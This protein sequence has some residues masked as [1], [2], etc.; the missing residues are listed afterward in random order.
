MNLISSVRLMA[1]N[2]LLES[3]GA[4]GKTVAAAVR[5]KKVGVDAVS[6]HSTNT[7]LIGAP[8]ITFKMDGQMS[9]F[10]VVQATEHVLSVDL[11]LTEMQ[12]NV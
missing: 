7:D 2:T 8:N 4:N 9:S 6:A 3:I 10:V 11:R 12:K 1:A 5:R